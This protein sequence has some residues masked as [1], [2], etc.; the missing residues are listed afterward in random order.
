[1]DIV[2]LCGGRG[3]RLLPFTD[4]MPKPLVKI[5]G[6]PLLGHIIDYFKKNGFNRFVF[7][8]GYKGHMIKKYVDANKMGWDVSYVDSGEKAS[9]I[10]RILDCQ[11]VVSDQ[12]MVCYGD[13]VAD[14]NLLKLISFH[15]KNSIT[16]TVTNLQSPF[17][18]VVSD[19]TGLVSSFE[20]KPYLDYWIYIGFMVFEK[21]T[22]QLVEGR[23][24]LVSLLQKLASRKMLYAYKHLGYHYTVNTEKERIELEKVFPRLEETC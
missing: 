19:D 14:V 7:C 13:T 4:L 18:I 11:S 2:F 8:I 24:G 9:I 17:G 5:R 6:K 16:I 21:R 20:E 22:L 3:T 1:M 15:R 10:K 23:D 12:F